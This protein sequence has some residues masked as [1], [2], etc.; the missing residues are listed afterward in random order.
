MCM[1]TNP[2]KTILQD[3]AGV[4]QVLARNDR[5]LTRLFL[6]DPGKLLQDFAG[7]L[8]NPARNDQIILLNILAGSFCLG[9]K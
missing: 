2:A 6:Q 8:Q 4:F 9:I 7:F 5:S 1:C 3:S